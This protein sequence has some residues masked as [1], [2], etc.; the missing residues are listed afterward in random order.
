MPAPY[1]AP[2]RR[3]KHLRDARPIAADREIR[4]IHICRVD[5]GTTFAQGS[6]VLRGSD[7]AG[8]TSGRARRGTDGAA[9][10][11]APETLR[12]TGP[13]GCMDTLESVA[14]LRPPKG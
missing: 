6:G 2:K 13:L 10:A 5:G 1:S 7:S 9:G 12:H 11:T 4:I 14:L 3:R 8:R